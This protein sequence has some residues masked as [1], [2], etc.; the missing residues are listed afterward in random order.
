MLQ[1]MKS[2]AMFVKGLPELIVKVIWRNWKKIMWKCMTG[3]EN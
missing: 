3:F 2:S 1:E